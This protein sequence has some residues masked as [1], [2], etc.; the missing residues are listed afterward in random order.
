MKNEILDALKNI[1]ND[2]EMLSGGIKI[3]YY[4]IPL[5]AVL[6]KLGFS[7]DTIVPKFYDALQELKEDGF[8]YDASSANGG[9]GRIIGVDGDV[10]YSTGAKI[11]LAH[12]N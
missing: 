8:I 11:R 4:E 5:S 1:H 12:V 2:S 3:P 9:F 10:S 6:Q 7:S